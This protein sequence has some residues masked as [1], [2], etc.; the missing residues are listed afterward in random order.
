MNGIP[1]NEVLAP[2]HYFTFFTPESWVRRL[3]SLGKF[4][5]VCVD[6][7]GQYNRLRWNMNFAH[8]YAIQIEQKTVIPAVLAMGAKSAVSIGQSVSLLVVA[9]VE[10]GEDT[11]DLAFPAD[12]DMLPAVLELVRDGVLVGCI[13]ICVDNIQVCHVDEGM[14]ERWVQ[15]LKRNARRFGLDP[16]KEELHYD[17]TYTLF[18]GMHYSKGLWNHGADRMERWQRK[19]G[20][21]PENT[22]SAGCTAKDWPL[23]MLSAKDIQRLVGVFVW[24]CRVRREDVSSVLQEIFG[25]Q[26]RACRA[27]NPTAPSQAEVAVLKLRW[28]KFQRNTLQTWREGVPPPVRSAR[29]ILVSDASGG[30]L[31]RWSFCEMISGRVERDGKGPVNPSGVFEPGVPEPI[32]YREAHGCCW[33]CV[34]WRF[35]GGGS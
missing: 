5:A 9:Y 21:V 6:I 3:R 26:Y 10:P 14:K 19:Y 12:P 32:Y 33:L 15:R 28:K 17:E 4:F 11:L 18:I 22:S 1:G 8:Y 30:P 25:I 35:R 13:H 7:K 20:I 2:P 34:A 24:D 29:C 31:G 27:D 23:R 16:F